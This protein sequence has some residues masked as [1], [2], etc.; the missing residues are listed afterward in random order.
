MMEEDPYHLLMCG[1]CHRTVESIVKE[2]EGILRWAYVV[3]VVTSVEK[4]L[5]AISNGLHIQEGFDS[6]V[7]KG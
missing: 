4:D 6:L 7:W 2:C 3:E 5:E 1:A